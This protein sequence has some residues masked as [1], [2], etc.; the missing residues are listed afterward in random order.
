M[1]I[2]IDDRNAL[3]KDWET[4]RNHIEITYPDRIAD[5]ELYARDHY[6]YL[7]QFIGPMEEIRSIINKDPHYY[8]FADNYRVA[9]VNDPFEMLIFEHIQRTGCCGS[10]NF[11]IE[12]EGVRYKVGFNF[13]H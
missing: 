2:P 12:L 6:G 5:L 13:G 10:L 8:E 1:Q 4:F 7:K 11:D 9:R 3:F